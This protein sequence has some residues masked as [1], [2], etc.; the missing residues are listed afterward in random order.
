M[1]GP[2]PTWVPP[3]ITKQSS[4]EMYLFQELKKLQGEVTNIK[5]ELNNK[6]AQIADLQAQVKEMKTM[7]HTRETPPNQVNEAA[8]HTHTEV[9]SLKSAHF[10]KEVISV[11]KEK[12]KVE[13]IKSYIRVGGLPLG[14][15]REDLDAE[16]Q[17]DYILETDILK[18]QLTKVVPFVDIGEPTL[19]E[20]KGK[21]AILHYFDMREKINVMKQARSLQGTKVWIADELTL[22]QLKNRPTELR[23]VKEAREAGKWA[24]YRGGEAIIRD[25]Y[26]KSPPP[27]EHK[28]PNH[29]IT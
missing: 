8:E 25:F 24:V 27:K 17:E 3:P 26:N 11:I 7:Q 5:Q 10:T 21:Q 23:K 6:D 15:D 4:W 19:I 1:G 29:V 16:K 28:K 2:L 14:W 13:S 22:L 12:E 20:V 9:N 18:E